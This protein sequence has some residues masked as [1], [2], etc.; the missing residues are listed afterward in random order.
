MPSFSGKI[1]I[2]VAYTA[3]AKYSNLIVSIVLGMLLSRLLTPNE[4]GIVALV[5]VFVSFFTLLSDIG[6]GPAII[7]SQTLDDE[8]IESIFAFSLVF[9]VLLSIVFFLLGPTISVFYGD[10]KLINV[11]RLLSITILFYSFQIV[12]NSLVQ[13]KMNFKKIGIINVTV[14]IFTGGIA[15][16]MA[17]RGFSYYSLVIKSILDGVLTF[18][19]FYL[20]NPV[21]FK[22]QIKINSIKKIAKFSFFQFLFNFVNYFSRNV[23]NL[24]IGKFISPTQLGFYDKSY[25][26]MLLPIANLTHIITPVLLPIFA[27]QNEDVNIIF[28][29]YIKMIKVLSYIGFPLSVFLYFTSSEI[30]QILYGINWQQSIPVFKVIA[31]SIGIQMVLSTS[32]SIFQVLNRT[33]LLFVSGLLSSITMITGVLYGVFIGKSLVDVGYG[34]NV[35][36]FIN[37]FQAFY[38]LIKIALKKSFLK[39]LKILI[40]PVLISL[41]L[42][43]CLYLF[44]YFIVTNNI[45]ALMTKALISIFVFIIVVYNIENVRKELLLYFSISYFK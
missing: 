43:I 7:Q 44:N 41:L 11:C 38:L 40:F 21:K 35:A 36:F 23:D 14:Q 22:F 42:S 45:I 4:F 17:Y 27:S 18:A 16:F 25:R 30:I 28:N 1:G 24:L 15:I 13:K 33:D 10:K 39:F 2:G 6:L 29:T 31:L 19:A 5:T 32:G 3:L 34:L 12:P 37:F 8:D 26:L 20:I 9:G